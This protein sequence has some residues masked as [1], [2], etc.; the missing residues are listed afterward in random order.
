MSVRNVNEE[1]AAPQFECPQN[2]LARTTSMQIQKLEI[3]FRFFFLRW[4]D[5]HR[6]R[7]PVADNEQLA[8]HS[9]FATTK[10]CVPHKRISFISSMF[11]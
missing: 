4:L 2:K 9:R 6:L 10:L 5:Q 3:F 7:E 1:C 11:T 8:I